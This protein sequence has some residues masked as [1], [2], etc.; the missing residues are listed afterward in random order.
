MVWK[1]PNRSVVAFKQFV[2]L[3]LHGS[4]FTFCGTE[5]ARVQCS[6]Y[7]EMNTGDRTKEISSNLYYNST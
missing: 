3:L 6:K 2:R 5:K 7:E 1:L 4:I